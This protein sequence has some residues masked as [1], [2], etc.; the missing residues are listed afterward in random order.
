MSVHNKLDKVRKP[1]IHIKYE[2][3]TE[4]T[5]EVKE[6]PFIAGVMGDFSGNNPGCEKK[7]LNTRKF[8]NIDQDNFDQVMQR[9]KPGVNIRVD[10]TLNDEQQ[11]MSVQLEF[12]SIEDFE[13]CNIIK[14]VP[15]L[16]KLKDTRDQL[17][18]LLSKADRSEEL[19][20]ILEQ[21]LNNDD[22]LKNIA[23]DL[24]LTIDE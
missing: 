19:E 18:D 1:R 22:L 8:T 13:P 5:T 6:L 2:I 16:K 20:N 12:N 17:R 3:E 10:N 24:N 15:S 9:I 23:K 11:E 4:D 14:Q 21:A 7:P